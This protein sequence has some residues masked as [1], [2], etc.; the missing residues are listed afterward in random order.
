M[1]LKTAQGKVPAFRPLESA[2]HPLLVR[3]RRAL[4]RGEPT[5]EGQLGV[6]GFHL[7][8][9]A[10]KSGLEV[11]ALIVSRSALDK[12]RGLLDKGNSS[13]PAYVVPDRVFRSASETQTP[14][15]I[16]ALVRLPEFSLDKCLARPQALVV[17]LV[18]VQEPGNLGTILRALEA[19][20]GSACLLTRKT[21]S[22][23]N[24][25]AVRASAGALFRLPVFSGLEAED[26]IRVCRKHGL[27]TVGLAPRA[28][29]TLTETDLRGPVALFVG[30]ESG[31]LPSA[32][33]NQMDTRASIPLAAPVD[34]LN[35][36]MAASL[37]LYEA[38]RQR[39]FAQ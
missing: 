9:E 35:A 2:R 8:E 24:A 4:H 1:P 11:G 16:A 27:R 13:F 22:L 12:A 20:G 28:R 6:E 38:A 25:K 10:L 19:F 23:F 26:A 18:E 21:V 36:A 32:V 17:V 3:L 33:L 30:S 14:Q 5:P 31:G 39:G 7:V 29:T 37:A 34:S 15:G